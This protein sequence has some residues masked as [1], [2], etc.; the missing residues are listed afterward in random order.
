MF[1]KKGSKTVRGATLIA[2][3]TRI[4][5]DVHFSDELY[6]NGHIDGN[7][8][9]EPDS[10]ATL[11]VSD[12]G[13]VSGEISVPCVVING[14]VVGDVYAGTRAELA[15]EARIAGNVY[16]KLME[17][18]LG[19]MVDGQ[20]VHV[21]EDGTEVVRSATPDPEAEAGVSE[22]GGEVYSH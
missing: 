20:L 7:V 14:R 5:G 3:N 16:Y 4:S 2:E 21:E 8:F 11:V 1:R 9:A 12:V 19:A 13:L 10:G 15:A 18:Q 17:M 6:V 22:M